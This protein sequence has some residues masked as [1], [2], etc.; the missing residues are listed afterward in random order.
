MAN[1]VAVL[2]RARGGDDRAFGELTDPYL[3]ELRLHCYRILGSVQDAEDVLQETLLAAWRGLGQ[4]EE[5]ASLRTWLYRIAT[6][7]CL[8]ALRASERRPRTAPAGPDFLTVEPTRRGEP[9]WLEP[10]PDT[11]LEGLPDVAAGPEARYE[12][13]E[14]VALAFVTAVQRLPGRQRAVLVLRDVLGFRA[15]EV[16]G[17]L[18][19]S[20]ASVNSALQRARATMAQRRPGPDRER[21][22]L[23]RS[24]RE[25]EVAARF[26]AAFSDND[27]DAVVALLTEDAWFT[28]PPATLEFQGRAAI[29]GFLRDIWGWRGPRPYRLVPVRAN[30]QVAF[31]CYLQAG[32]APGYEGHGMIVLTLAGD[33]ISALT[34]FTDNGNLA[35]FGLP[36][37][38]AG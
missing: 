2:D 24:A 26:A 15:G 33:M 13:K 35:R 18:A 27:V 32:S 6:N 20:E 22:P 36:L 38:L 12:A 9:L 10:Y 25:R 17:M 31:G 11:L 21:A 23:P 4:Y 3:G 16:A 30:G 37:A 14:A 28:M 7:R 8:N 1:S 19:T 5:R 29:A 34:R